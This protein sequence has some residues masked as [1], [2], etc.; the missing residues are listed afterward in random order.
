VSARRLVPA[1][2]ALAILSP[3]ARARELWRRGDV[4]VELTGSTKEIA[5]ATYGTDSERFLSRAATSPT[6][7]LAAAFEHCPALDTVGHA[8]APQSLTRLRTH[9]D[10][11]VG[12]WLTGEL[13]YDHE[14]RFGRLDT[15]AASLADDL[16]AP[17]LV[18][19][20]WDVDAFGLPTDTASWQHSL[21]RAD[22]KL[23][24]R[25][26]EVTVGRQRIPWGVGR[27]W[28]PTD[29]F[30]F[31]RPLAIE[32]DETPGVEAVDARWN[33]SGFSYLE[34]VWEPSRHRD[35]SAYAVRAHGTVHDVD[36]SALAGRWDGAWAAGFDAAG[37][38]GGS[39]ARIE[40]IWTDPT[41]QVWPLDASHPRELA[42]FWQVVASIDHEFD[43]GS[44]LYVLVEHL[45]NGNALGFH[46][47]PGAAV[48]PF[49]E[50]TAIPPP[51]V[52]P[53]TPGPF[54]RPVS[55][56]RFGGSQ[57][58]SLAHHQTAIDLG[59]D[60]TPVL[61]LDV[62]TIGDWNGPSLAFAPV[63]TWSPIGAME[64]KLG[65]Q[66]FAGRRASEYGPQEPLGYLTM[67]WF[68]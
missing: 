16:A 33:L 49:F 67:E 36:L 47:G 62:L 51:G 43:V 25:K 29:R 42:P 30:N 61:R 7:V 40:A 6:C 60:L 28:Q 1:V 39:A 19:L 32:P 3:P 50:A 18:D 57:V 48:L 21:Y 35:D 55:Q 12:S 63:L 23:E 34:A 53:G 46:S 24:V 20:D 59:Y 66:L 44:G 65:V 5:L 4:S 11:H 37:N 52:P 27:I 58:I 56:D 8:F 10:V 22:L 15:L 14:W 26:L 31:V 17:P 9:L 45:Y 54:V 2:L 64:L 68:F 41:R 13:V 38:L